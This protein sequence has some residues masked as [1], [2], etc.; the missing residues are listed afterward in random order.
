MS[1]SGADAP[2]P[3]H[4]GL[5][6]VRPALPDRDPSGRTCGRI[7]AGQGDPAACGQ[8]RSVSLPAFAPLI[9]GATTSGAVAAILLR[10]VATETC[11]QR[12]PLKSSITVWVYC[13]C[14]KWPG[15]WGFFTVSI[16]NVADTWL[17]DAFATRKNVFAVPTPSS[18][19]L[20]ASTRSTIVFTMSC[21][22]IALVSTRLGFFTIAWVIS[23]M[24]AGSDGLRNF[25]FL[26]MSSS[27]K[28]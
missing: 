3:R 12:R 2:N 21:P 10:S 20:V 24:D 4:R 14:R 22:A 28:A 6:R 18:L 23:G 25:F 17:A 9:E 26:V 19:A 27:E 11:G 15:L 16:Q 13:S 8:V 1:S 7:P 5:P